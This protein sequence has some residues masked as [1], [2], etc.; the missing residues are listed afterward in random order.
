MTAVVVVALAEAACWVV[1]HD[2]FGMGDLYALAIWSLPFGVLVALAG[3]ALRRWNRPE[4]RAVRGALAAALGAMLG[5]LWTLA[6]IQMMGPWFG[7]LSFPVLPI[8]AIAGALTLGVIASFLPKPVI[9][10]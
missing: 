6:M 9:E 8:L 2:G 5:L 4:R 1:L 7:T 3:V 10:A